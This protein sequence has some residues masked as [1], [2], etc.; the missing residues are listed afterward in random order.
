L[1]TDLTDGIVMIARKGLTL[2]LFFIGASLTKSVL[3][4]V[5]VRPMIQ[6]VLIWIVISVVSLSYIYFIA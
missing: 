4:N 2:S 5:G 1:P 6:G 3:R